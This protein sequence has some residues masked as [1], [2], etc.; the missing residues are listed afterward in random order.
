MHREGAP[1]NESHV[2]V[3]E[4]GIKFVHGMEASRGAGLRS[5][6]HELRNEEGICVFLSWLATNESLVS[7]AVSFRALAGRRG[8]PLV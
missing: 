2:K 4:D 5:R 7:A 3:A 6:A 8:V 1:K